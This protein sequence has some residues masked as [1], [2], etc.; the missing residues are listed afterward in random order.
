MIAWIVKRLM[1]MLPM[2]LFRRSF[3][4]GIISFF[5]LRKLS[6]GGSNSRRRA[7]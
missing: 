4:G 6:R 2:F 7:Y 1:F 3:L 5:L